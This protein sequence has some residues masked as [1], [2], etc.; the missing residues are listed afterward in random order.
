MQPSLVIP[1]NSPTPRARNSPCGL[2]HRSGSVF[3]CVGSLNAGA[4]MADVRS[5]RTALIKRILEGDGRASS[6]ERTAAF[7][8]VGLAGPVGAL[9][10]KVAR[11]AYQV[12]DDDIAAVGSS[13]RSED[14]V[15]EIVV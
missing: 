6:S 11:H 1:C 9:V 7:H 8:P 15:F 10:D 5:A 4:P 3:A 14:Q 13:G 12:T 2:S